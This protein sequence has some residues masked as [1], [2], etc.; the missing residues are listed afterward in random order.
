[1]QIRGFLMVAAIA[2]ISASL[3]A[4]TLQRR[5]VM[6]GTNSGRGK[7]TI[8]VVVDGAADVEVR[9]DMGILRNLSGRPPQWRRFECNGV[10]PANPAEFR[11]AGVDGRGRQQ[12][13]RDPRDGGAAV[14]RIEDPDTGSEGYTFNLFW[15]G[16]GYPQT[17]N[18]YPQT[19]NRYPDEGE[20]RFDRPPGDR[21]EDFYHREREESFR[22]ENWRDRFFERVR[23]DIEH[24]QA[25]AFPYGN[26]QYRLARTKQELNELQAGVD[27]GRY[28]DRDL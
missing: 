4:Q 10:M 24:A 28:N 18:G 1:M 27:S 19:Q 25:A 11:F 22:R 9:G 7:C 2:G 26:D 23:E 6:N 20:R 15:G 14:V 5:A 13:I 16:N 17:G 12:L 21:D 8:E 3:S